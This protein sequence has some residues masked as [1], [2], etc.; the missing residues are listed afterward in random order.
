MPRSKAT[1]IIDVIWNEDGSATVLGRLTARDG[2]GTATGVKG[3]GNWLKQADLSTITF[4][5]YDEA[6]GTQITAPTTVTISSSVLD[7]PDTTDVLWTKDA[8][9]YNF[10]HDLGPANFPTGGTIYRVEYKITTNSGAVGWGKYRGPA[11]T[12]LTS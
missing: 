8:T 10:I 6:D 3:E 2:T 1:D 4:S 7:K 12:A 11:K 9:G 5:V